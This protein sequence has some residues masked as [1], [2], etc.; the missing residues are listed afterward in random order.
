M[1]EVTVSGDKATFEVNGL[2]K[3]WSLKSR[4]EI[5]LAHIKGVQADPSHALGW[6]KG[7]GLV[8]TNVPNIF[9]AGTFYQE[10]N[11]IFWDV[12]NPERTIVVD[13]KDENYSKLIVEVEDPEASVNLLNDAISQHQP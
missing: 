13:L 1:V 2:H 5:P 4:L 8:G 12:R 7:L 11:L 6:F 10:G 9:R 3:L